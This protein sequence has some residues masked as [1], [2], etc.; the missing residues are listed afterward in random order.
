MNEGQLAMIHPPSSTPARMKPPG[1]LGIDGGGTKTVCVVMDA[2]GAVWG[3]GEAGPSNYQTIGI[4]AATGAIAEA[5]ARATASVPGLAIAGIGVGL[6]GVGR[7]QDVATA[8]ALVETLP[9]REGLSVNW[10]LHPQGILVTHDCAIALVGGTG[11]TEGVVT[12]AGTGSIAYGCNRAGTTQRAGG[13]GYLLGDEGSGYDIALQ[14]LRAAVRSHDGRSPVTMLTRGFMDRLQLNAPE[15]LIEAIYRRGWGVKQ[16]ASL[17]PVVDEAA[18]AGDAVA[19][20]I[21]DH[22]AAE[23]GLITQTVAQG[24]FA[25]ADR[26]EVVTMGGVWR[27]VDNMRDRFVRAIVSRFPRAQVIWPRHHPAEGAALLVRRQIGIC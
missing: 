5:I 25:I 1:V 6:A 18:T 27:S 11:H 2:S 8:R 10:Q 26:F 13:W 9:Q 20:Q 7:P 15:D 3:R 14:G 19:N 24:L 22:A 23:L 4:E 12:I 17:A 16:I 21:M